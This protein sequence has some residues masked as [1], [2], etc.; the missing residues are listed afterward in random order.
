MNHFNGRTARPLGPGAAPGCGEPT[1]RCRT[2]PSMWTLG[3]YQPVI[4]GVAFIRWSLALPQ[5][6]SGSLGPAFASAR[7]VCLAVKPP[8]ALVL[9]G[10][11]LTS[12]RGPLYASVTL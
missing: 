1:S 9:N 12:L 5:S 7:R 10:W 8:F 3:R 4:P 2:P 6:A 11:S